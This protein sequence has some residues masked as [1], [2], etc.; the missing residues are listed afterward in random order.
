MP[1]PGRRRRRASPGHRWRRAGGHRLHLG[2]TG[3]SKGACHP[4]QLAANA[5]RSSAAGASPAPTATGGAA[6]LPR[7]R[8]R[9][10]PVRVARLGC[11]MRLAERFERGRALDWFEDSGRRSSSAYRPSTCACSSCRRRGAAIGAGCGCSCRDRRPS[12]RRCSSIPRA[13]RPHHPGAVR[14]ERDVHATSN[15]LRGRAPRRHRG[16]PAAGGLA[17]GARPGR[18]TGRRRAKSARCRRGPTVFRGYWRHAAATTAA[19]TDGWF[20][21]GDIG[22][23]DAAGCSRCAGARAT[24]HLRRLQHLSARDRGSAPRTPGRAEAAVV[25]APDTGAVKCPWPTSSPSPASTW[26]AC[27]TARREPRVLQGAARLRARRRAAQER[28]GQAPEAPARHATGGNRPCPATVSDCGA[29]SRETTRP[30]SDTTLLT[31]LSTFA[32]LSSPRARVERR[33]PFSKPSR[34]S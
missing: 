33:D 21:T 12:R 28:A 2:T 23:L 20:R 5:P 24:D 17:V 19:F 25:G 13:V 11:L 10:R 16:L 7:P 26:T 29:Q 22:E 30:T 34:S 6:A 32:T 3:R 9:Q 1:R 18:P 8:P 27:A 15:L 31:V 14:D 4:R